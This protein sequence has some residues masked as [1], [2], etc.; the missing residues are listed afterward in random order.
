MTAGKGTIWAVIA[1]LA[2]HAGWLTVVSI[3][4][5]NTD[6][7]LQLLDF[8][9]FF[10]AA[11]AAFNAGQSPYSAA[12][13][14]GYE[15]GLGLKVY[16]FVYP[17]SALPAFFPFSLFGYDAGAIVMMTAN[18]VAFAYLVV[19]LSDMLIGRIG[20]PRVALLC[21]VIL[22]IFD[23]ITRTLWNGQINLFVTILILLAWERA[24]AGRSLWAGVILGLAA[25]LK[26]YPAVLF[27]VFLVRGDHRALLAGA[28]AVAG[29][30]ALSLVLLPVEYWREWLFTVAPSADYTRT[31]FALVEAG[32]PKNQSLNGLFS[33]L[34]ADPAL[35]KHCAYAASGVILAASA[36]GVWG[37]RR[38]DPWRYFGLG[39]SI[40][41][42][43][44]IFVAPWSWLHHYVFSLPAMVYLLA[45]A[46]DPAN[47][48]SDRWRRVAVVLVCLNA[49]PWRLTII[50]IEH[51]NNLPI[52]P[53]LAMWAMLLSF[54]PLFRRRTADGI[55][56]AA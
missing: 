10:S 19:K 46:Y 27:L 29:C 54:T 23:P 53:A 21:L 51:L 30:I 2:F 8:S 33:R 40:L 16:P 13:M 45:H 22:V 42:L 24:L 14:A 49:V 32:H 37:L 28:A 43:A 55:P 17:P 11:D 44:T 56:A 7:P 15:A 47:G 35:A 20:S 1:G 6:M 38:L 26:T 36:W 4:R 41:I 48:V 12:V 31:P 3:F 50:E 25:V 9:S 5:L 52:L 39:F 34:F 18:A